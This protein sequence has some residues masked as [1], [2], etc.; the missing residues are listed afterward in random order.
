MS[1]RQVCFALELVFKCACVLLLVC[2]CAS[3]LVCLCALKQVCFAPA[4][5]GESQAAL[6]EREGLSL[7]QHDDEEE[8][9]KE[10]GDK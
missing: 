5:S 7:A 4:A 6:T 3:V 9:L 8:K 2:L 1:L 10:D